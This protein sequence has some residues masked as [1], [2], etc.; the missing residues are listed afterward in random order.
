MDGLA[1]A[2]RPPRRLCLGSGN[3]RLAGSSSP[4]PRGGAM[5]ELLAS[6]GYM[7]WVLPVLLALPIAGAAV[8]WVHGALPSRAE[9]GSD[10]EVRSGR[11]DAPR[12]IAAAFFGLEFLI[13]LGL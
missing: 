7:S 9:V 5:N 3:W 2:N 10:D 11:A 12:W 8:L 4:S 6:V 13:S 1:A